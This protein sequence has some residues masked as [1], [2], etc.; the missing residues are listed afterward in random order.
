M[1]GGPGT[2]AA[3]AALAWCAVP[4][5][6]SAR[7][8]AHATHAVPSIPDEILE[9]PIS[10]RSGIGSAHD[11]V[12]TRS[13]GAQALYDQG[14][15]YLHSY[16]WILAA[17]SF[18]AALREDPALAMAHVGLSV[19]YEEVNQPAAANAFLE[20]ARARRRDVSAHDRRHM[21]LRALQ[22]DATQPGAGS[23]SLRVYRRALDAALVDLPSDAELWLLRG[24]AEAPGAADRGQGSTDSSIAFYA[25]ALQVQAGHFA[26]H[27]YLTHA[28]EN[29]GRIAE[30]LKHAEEYARL[31]PAVPHAH[32]MRGHDLRRAGRTGEAIGAFRTAYDLEQKRAADVPAEHDWHH[33]HNLDLLA[34]SH[35][36]VGQ[37][38]A[39]ERFLQA[40]FVTPS[41]LVVQAFN[42]HEWPSFLLAIG[43]V[44]DALVAAGVLQRSPARLVRGMGHVMAGRAF[45][46]RREFEQA[47]A[48]SNR[49]LAELR[50][51]G[52]EASLAAPHLQALQAEFF[53]RTGRRERAV[54]AFRDVRR[55]IRALPG[56][57]GWSQGLFRLEA[58]GRAAV[59]AGAWDVAKETADDLHAHDP[60]YGGTHHLLALVA[61][62]SGDRAATIRHL[63]I[64]ERAWNEADPDFQ[65]LLDVR[66]RL[67]R[68]RR[69]RK[70]K[71]GMRKHELDWCRGV[72]HH[73]DRVVARGCRSRVLAGRGAGA[74]GRGLRAA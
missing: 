37:V 7:Q 35:Q 11:R 66:V 10:L 31:A 74:R 55:A 61:E 50:A 27:H 15:A 54:T 24:M 45:L 25:R 26:A 52:P 28:H 20:R 30:A 39:A 73:T 47:A 14:L 12:T 22:L 65:S 67:A 59:A 13:S 19:A 49:A 48:A 60:T 23:E 46:A 18:H 64:A 57:D 6:S 69:P 36:H 44:H 21:E 33:Q 34:A 68:V 8:D 1:R 41:A 53:L 51:A 40:S 4:W 71:G 2:I 5:P 63:E 62:Q 56:P 72:A 32:H 58:I 9:R 70:R 3:V 17:R 43:R 16:E 42:K 38:R 29:A